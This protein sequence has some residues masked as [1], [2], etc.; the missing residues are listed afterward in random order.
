MIKGEYI[1]FVRNSLQMVDQTLKYHT[2]QVA[3]AIDVASASVFWEMYEKNPKV[4]KKALERYSTLENN[5]VVNSVYS[6]RYTTVL[7]VDVVDLPK[8]AGGVLEIFA[9]SSGDMASAQTVFVPVS[10]IEGQQLYGSESSLPNNVVGFSLIRKNII[11][12]WGNATLLASLTTGAGG[13]GVWVRYIKRFRDYSS[14]DR[15][16]MPYGQDERIVELV[17]EYLS[18]IPPK[19]LVNDNADT[20]G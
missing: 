12:Y 9:D 15:V 13:T 3:A 19:D 17:R 14:T 18:G 16:E 8:K 7:M 2:E 6:P 1:D 10:T 11:E 20:N 4:M 5:T